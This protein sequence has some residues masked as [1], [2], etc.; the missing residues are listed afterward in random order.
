MTPARQ[1]Y[2]K[3]QAIDQHDFTVTMKLGEVRMGEARAKLEAVPVGSP[4]RAAAERKLLDLEIV[5]FR[6]RVERQPTDMGHRFLLGKCLYDL[7]DI[8]GSAA[9]F[10]RSVN[11]PRLRKSS[12]LYL[13]RC[14]KHKNLLDLAIAQYKL[15]LPLVDDELSIEAKDGR[16]QLAR[17]YEDRGN[18]AEAIVEYEKLVAIDLSFK[19]AA[20]RLSK[21]RGA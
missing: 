12:H 9:E 8:D 14:F 20:T 16:Y 2:E 5:E 13:G 10:Q 15:F 1:A 6:A 7:G 11:D 17:L 18:I 4:E 3:A 19:D 21:L